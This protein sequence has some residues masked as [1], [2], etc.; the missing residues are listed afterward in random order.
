M[1]TDPAFERDTLPE[2][3][4]QAL[5]DFIALP[6]NTPHRQR[7]T[8]AAAAI[9]DALRDIAWLDSLVARYPYDD[10][11]IAALIPRLFPGERWW[12][13]D[14]RVPRDLAY[15]LRYI[16]IATG[17]RLDPTRPLPWWVTEWTRR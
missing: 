2:T 8:R 15:A 10:A 13:A 6:F 4:R 3:W 5:E 16:E 12:I 14:L 7:L 9:K 17:Q 1:V 11:R